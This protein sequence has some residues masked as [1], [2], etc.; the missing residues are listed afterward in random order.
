MLRFFRMIFGKRF[1]LRITCYLF[2]DIEIYRHDNYLLYLIFQSLQLLPSPDLLVM[3]LD[4]LAATELVAEEDVNNVSAKEDKKKLLWVIMELMLELNQHM[5][6][7]ET[8]LE[9]QLVEMTT[10]QCWRNLFPEFQGKITQSMPKSPKLP[11]L[12]TVK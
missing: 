5:L 4:T 8:L 10:L 9:A 11:S 6:V 1:L 12:A 2:V 3:D 7:T